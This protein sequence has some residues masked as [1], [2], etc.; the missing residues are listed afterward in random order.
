MAIITVISFYLCALIVSYIFVTWYRLKKRGS[1]HNGA[2]EIF[3]ETLG[4]EH[5][6]Y[7]LTKVAIVTTIGLAVIFTLSIYGVKGIIIGSLLGVLPPLLL[8]MN[9][10]WRKPNVVVSEV[11]ATKYP[12]KVYI[13]GS[14]K[15]RRSPENAI[16]L[17]VKVRNDGRTTAKNC[18]VSLVSDVGEDTQY[19]TRWS[20]GNYIHYDLAPGETKQ[21]DLLWIG[22]RNYKVQTPNPFRDQ[23][24]EQN[25]PPGDYSKDYRHELEGRKQ[26]LEIRAD[27][28]NMRPV[29]RSLIID[30]ERE[31]R[32]P[33]DIIDISSEWEFVSLLK[34]GQEDCIIYYNERG[35]EIVELPFNEDLGILPNYDEFQPDRFYIR[36]RETYEEAISR[37]M[38]IRRY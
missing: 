30:G 18:K 34:R 37:T 21:L 36:D 28:D 8:Q 27:A 6:W 23:D 12:S 22:L 24:N 15:D 13:Y 11:T 4:I 26:R 25:D 20:E 5:R 3:W 16:G 31:I 29:S 38:T 19:A 33:Q 32:V 9:E 14:Q 35:Q 1:I 7:Q 10:S 2:R 17:H